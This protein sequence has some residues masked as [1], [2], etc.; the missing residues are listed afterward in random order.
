MKDGT[1]Q[2]NWQ[3]IE[4]AATQTAINV[5]MLSLS[6]KAK[7]HLGPKNISAKSKL[8]ATHP[9]ILSAGPLHG[10]KHLPI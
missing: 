4:K 3:H 8:R 7:F 5:A 2:S 10:S 1:V 9:Y 6:Y